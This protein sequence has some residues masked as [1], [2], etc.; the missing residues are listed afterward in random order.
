LN[1][2]LPVL[3]VSATSGA[4]VCRFYGLLGPGIHFLE[5]PLKQDA[6]VS[7]V[8]LIMDPT[9]LVRTSGASSL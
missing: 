5:K 9:V 2:N 6:F 8:R 4:E 3:F 7:M 1:A